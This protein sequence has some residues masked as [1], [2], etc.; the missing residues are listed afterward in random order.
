M[1]THLDF[2]ISV[3]VIITICLMFRH[4]QNKN[5]R[6]ERELN[7]YRTT[8]LSKVGCTSLWQGSGGKMVNYEL[9]S[10]DA[11]KTWYAVERHGEL[12]EYLTILGKA[13]VVYPGL[14]DSLRKTDA[15]IEHV[16]KN[17]PLTFKS[18]HDI[19]LLKD[20]G[21]QVEVKDKASE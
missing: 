15:L 16:E 17:G 21:F 14:M 3:A 10:F 19:Q 20:I 13:E 2:L 9:R 7:H 12:G 18:D 4:V 1:I 6:M 5:V 8:Y 11:G